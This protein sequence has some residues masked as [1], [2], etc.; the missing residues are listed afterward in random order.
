MAFANLASSSSHQTQNATANSTTVSFT[1]NTP[2]KLDQSNYL[3]WRSQILASI[4]GNRLEKFIDDSI[5]PPSSHIAQRVDDE[6]RSVENSEFTTWRSQDQVLL[7]WLLSSM[8]EG[9]ITLVFNLETS[10]GVWKAIEMKNIADNMAAAGSAL[11]SDDLILHVLS[12]LGLDYNSVATYITGQVGVGKMNINEAYAM[13]LTQE[14]KIE[15]QSQML[16]GVDMKN[17]FEANYA[18]NRGVKKNNMS[19]GRGFGGYGYG[20]SS[21]IGNGGYYKGN[22]DTDS[23]GAGTSFN[24]QFKGYQSGN[25][26]GGGGGNWNNNTGVGNFNNGKPINPKPQWNTSKPTCQICLRPGHTA[27]VCWKLEDFMASGAYRPPPNRG[28]KAAY[29]ANMDAP[30]DTNWYL[31]SGATHHLTNDV[32]NMHMAEPFAGTSKLVIGNGV[33]LCITHTG[34]AVLRMQR[35]VNDFELKLNN[36][37]LVP[38]ITKNLISISK[39]TRDNDVVIEF[40]ND[41]CFVKDKVRNLIILQGKAEKGLYR[42]LLV[43]ANKPSPYLSNQG[44]LA[45]VQSAVS[46]Q[47]ISMFSA[48]SSKCQNKTISQSLSE[49]QCSQNSNCMLSTMILH[50]KLGYN[51][52]H[53]SYKCL[54]SSGKVYIA[55][56]VLFDET[57]FPYSTDPTFLQSM[58]SK[59]S[60]FLYNTLHFYHISVPNSNQN[61]FEVAPADTNSHA[62]SSTHNIISLPLPTSLVHSSSLHSPNNYIT[63]PAATSNT[64]PAATSNTTPSLIINQT[65]S[66]MPLSASRSL[67]SPP[68]SIISTHPMIT[69]AKAGIFKPKAFLT[70]HNSL[71]PSNV[72]EALSDS[73]WKA[74]MQ[75]EFDAL[76][77]NKTWSLVP[78]NPEY[79]LVGCK[80]VFRTKYNTDGSV[81]KYK[82]RLVAKGFH[83]RASIDYS[84]TFSHVVKS[85][86]VRVIL[87]LA[88][89]QSWNVRQIDV[90]N[91]FLNGDLTEDVYMHQPEGFVSQGGC[92]CKLNKALYGLKQAPRA[93]YDKLKGCLTS[94][95]FT[96]SKADTSLFVRHDVKCIILVLIYVDDILITGPDFDLLESFIAKHSKVFALKDL[97]LVTYFLSVEVSYTDHGM[98]LS[99]TK[100]IKDLLSKASMQNCKEIDTPFSTCYKLER[101]AKGS[102]GAEFENPT[103]YRSI[104]L[105]YLQAT[106]TYGLYIQ[107]EGT[108]ETI[109]LT[110]YSDADWA[111]DIDDRKSIGAYC[112][113][114]ARNPIFHSRS[115]HIELDVHYIRDKVINKELEVRYI[116]TEEQVADVLTKPL[117]FPKFSY[118]RSKL[119]VISRPLNLRGDVKEAHMCRVASEAEDCNTC[120]LQIQVDDMACQLEPG[121]FVISCTCED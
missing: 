61:P 18:Q 26:R 35:S 21:G 93:W 33:G 14:A 2:V 3:I 55:S 8:S 16:A 87:S 25:Q 38:K 46:T 99:Q 42:L 39:L 86:T 79:K 80:W 97:G 74:A 4:R 94:W 34:C 45:H 60:D 13:L 108:L 71:E 110:G 32:S 113:F 48:V 106:V 51:P 92:V 100:Y 72:D 30:A 53:K 98:H 107:Q 96:N 66:N 56:H 41:F 105:R 59:S 77:R 6:L 82:A 64:T 114:L 52:L 109:G 5:T 40:T 20:H 76:I 27:N 11:S 84:E 9:I 24:N 12:G 68:N 81:S 116:P 63:S 54:H 50:Q 62:S 36:I 44:L 115:K 103:L 85:S 1:F 121:G 57:S 58:P 91:A 102:L 73:K 19:G 7:G 118:F 88:V 104:V 43:S 78:M 83:Q 75:A 49:A 65:L 101:L 117:S 22:F 119:N 17:N 70:A 112:I 28:Q 69:R 120:S 15:Q 37:I 90:N 95:N 89:M 111:C 29:L 67:P 31:D 47:P 23:A 10:L